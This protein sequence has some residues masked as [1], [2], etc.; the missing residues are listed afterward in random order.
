MPRWT[1]ITS[2]AV[3]FIEDA[4]P[5]GCRYGLVA[6]MD[7][8]PVW[9]LGRGVYQR[10]G[11]LLLSAERS[12]DPGGAVMTPAERARPR[13]ATELLFGPGEDAAGALVERMARAGADG[14]L[15]T[16]LEHLPA[17]ARAAAGREVAGQAAGLLDVNL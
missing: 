17:A 6:G 15:G 4:L 8:L 16:G 3:A 10:R 5:P 12:P 2:S 1:S 7:S 13:T 11:C 14:N 9:T